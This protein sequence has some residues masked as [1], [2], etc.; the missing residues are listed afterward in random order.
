M[1]NRSILWRK[2]SKSELR[3][4]E[5]KDLIKEYKNCFCVQDFLKVFFKNKK[6]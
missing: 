3:K 5:L 1:I 6:K 2:P 4:K